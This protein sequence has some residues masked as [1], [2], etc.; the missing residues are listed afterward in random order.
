MLPRSLRHRAPLLWILLP[1]MAGIVAGNWT[2]GHVRT[3]WIVGQ[4]AAALGLA[5][6]FRTRAGVWAGAF[7]VAIFLLSAAYFQLRETSPNAFAESPP[8]E[9]LLRLEI[10]RVFLNTDTNSVRSN[11]VSGIGRIVSRSGNAAGCDMIYFSG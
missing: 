7:L 10:Q 5:W 6:R 11:R 3:A 2:A 9:R 8:S 4:G 1:M